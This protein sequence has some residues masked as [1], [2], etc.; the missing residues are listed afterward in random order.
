MA[1]RQGKNYDLTAFDADN[2]GTNTQHATA[3][4]Y[5]VQAA[6]AAST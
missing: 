6:T 5:S 2:Y 4:T 1:D 3:A